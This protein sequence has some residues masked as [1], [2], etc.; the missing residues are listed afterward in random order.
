VEFFLLFFFFLH[1]SNREGVRRMSDASAHATGRAEGLAEAER[2][3]NALRDQVAQLTAANEHLAMTNRQQAQMSSLQMQQMLLLQQQVATSGGGSGGSGGGGGGSE[4]LNVTLDRTFRRI[5][6]GIKAAELPGGT[7][8][9]A[10]HAVKRAMKDEL[11]AVT[12]AAAAAA[13]AR[14]GVDPLRS[15]VAVA[16][17]VDQAAATEAARVAAAAEAEKRAAEAA[18]AE[19]RAARRRDESQAKKMEKERATKEK[20]AR[21]MAA[22]AAQREEEAAAAVAAREREAEA[23]RLHDVAAAEAEAEAA[24]KAAAKAAAEEKKARAKA[25]K[26][27]AKAAKRAAKE[28][29]RDALRSKPRAAPPPMPRLSSSG[30]APPPM[31]KLS[32]AAVAAAS[33]D[34]DGARNGTVFDASGAVFDAK[35]E[36]KRARVVNFPGGAGIGIRLVDQAKI[37]ATA[38]IAAPYA[39]KV[40]K[41]KDNDDGTLGAAEASGVVR[42]HDVVAFVDGECVRDVPFKAV[43]G[44]IKAGAKRLSPVTGAP[45]GFTLAFVELPNTAAAGPPKRVAAAS[46]S[47]SAPPAAAAAAAVK[48]KKAK[49]GRAVATARAASSTAVAARGEGASFVGWITDVRVSTDKVN[50]VG[51]D[52]GESTEEQPGA[53]D[54][55]G[56]AS[57]SAARARALSAQTAAF[58]IKSAFWRPT[59]A[60]PNAGQRDSVV[61]VQRHVADFVWLHAQLKAQFAFVKRG[62]AA[63]QER[64]ARALVPRVL[65]AKGARS[66]A[67]QL[68]LWLDWV[69]RHPV[70]SRSRHVHL[71][72]RSKPVLLGEP[73]SAWRSRP[74]SSPHLPEPPPAPIA[75]LDVWSN[76]MEAEF[77]KYELPDAKDRAVLLQKCASTGS[78]RLGTL[79]SRRAVASES[80]SDFSAAVEALAEAEQS[81]PAPST[82]TPSFNSRYSPASAAATL[83]MVNV[84]KPAVHKMVLAIAAASQE[85]SRRERMGSDAMQALYERLRFWG[86]SGL[87]VQSSAFTQLE[88]WTAD[89][90]RGSGTPVKGKGTPTKLARRTPTASERKAT[91][92]EQAQFSETALNEFNWAT[93]APVSNKN[94]RDAFLKAARSQLK[95][96]RATRKA[97]VKMQ[98]HIVRACEKQ[99]MVDQQREVNAHAS[100]LSS[101]AE[102]IEL[103]ERQIREN[104]KPAGVVIHG[105]GVSRS[106]VLGKWTLSA[107]RVADHALVGSGRERHAEFSVHVEATVAWWLRSKRG[108]GDGDEE[109]DEDAESARMSYSHTWTTTKRFSEFTALRSELKAEISQSATLPALCFRSLPEMAKKGA[110]SLGKLG[111]VFGA[112]KEHDPVFLDGRLAKLQTFIAAV[113]AHGERWHLMGSDALISWVNTTAERIAVIGAVAAQAD[114]A[115]APPSK[116]K[117]KKKKKK[118]TTQPSHYGAEL[119]AAMGAPPAAAP[120][121]VSSQQP[122]HADSSAG[123]D[124]DHDTMSRPMI[125]EQNRAPSTK[126]RA[127]ARRAAASRARDA[128]EEATAAVKEKAAVAAT[129]EKKGGGKAAAATA[130]HRSDASMSDADLMDAYLAAQKAAAEEKEKERKAASQRRQSDQQRSKLSRQEAL[131]RKREAART[132]GA[133]GGR[134]RARGGRHVNLSPQELQ[135]QTAKRAAE[136]QAAAHLDAKRRQMVVERQHIERQQQQR[137]RALQ[138]QREAERARKEEVARKRVLQKEAERVQANADARLKQQRRA[139]AQLNPSEEAELDAASVHGRN[140]QKSRSGGFT[141]PDGSGASGYGRSRQQSGS[142]SFIRPDGSGSGGRNRQKSASGGF[143]RSSSTNNLGR[144]ESSSS[145]DMSAAPMPA[146]A[147]ASGATSSVP[148]QKSIGGG[149]VEVATPD[150]RVYYYH[151]KTRVTRWERPDASV[152]DRMEREEKELKVKAQERVAV[153]RSRGAQRCWC[154]RSRVYALARSPTPPRRVRPLPRALAGDA[155]EGK[156]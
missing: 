46:A 40:G 95:H 92:L 44:R 134:A 128:Q 149:W 48:K 47:G 67:R 24:A 105:G 138:Q 4:A 76:P 98:R 129:A 114:T 85:T 6:A 42:L 35:A 123:V 148:A 37:A 73:R 30:A 116:K 133:G 64:G 19:Q 5:A 27:E 33:A 74:P 70:V 115:K 8:A 22:V 81:E 45:L 53:R 29:T 119:A 1:T 78:S 36:L 136:Q 99:L 130:Q 79:L 31:P 121:S 14:G 152:I 21:E 143:T 82:P 93:T 17:A 141:R 151:A 2:E 20:R 66:R 18:A 122:S 61:E 13:A 104:A 50:D 28:A 132:A 91:A 107:L 154:S 137:E 57:P 38:Q 142:G 135:Q 32:A 49:S 147:T 77:V 120:T 131:R 54:G 118:K 150:A 106:V 112:N 89:A 69:A 100:G 11:Q 60:D 23:Q 90:A 72:L 68:A 124:L 94:V 126:G 83:A 117:K 39:A 43:V 63:E 51:S 111:G 102:R 25:A 86:A 140:R 108:D 87:R 34:T 144:A 9:T 127:A 84:E 146:V 75:A 113:V 3:L 62:D 10:L 110:W 56:G 139:A 101:W 96:A 71:F 15:H 55:S 156:S 109:E 12:A 103:L 52:A 16:A 59:A 88:K 97:W 58:T 7:E 125:P 155:R 153:R 145:P 26:K 80:L 65:S 41:F